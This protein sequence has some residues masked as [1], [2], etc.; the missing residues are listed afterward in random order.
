M[1]RRDALKNIGLAA[2]F[3]VITPNIFGMLQSCTSDSE[4]W[5]PSFLTSDEKSLV[6][7]IV[8]VFLPKTANTPSA[9]EV[10]VAQFIDTYI[11]DILGDKDQELTRG[12]FKKIIAI[13]TPDSSS[14]IEDVTTEEYK[15]LLDKYLL[16]EEIDQEALEMSNSEFLNQLKWMTIT[17]YKNSKFVGENILAYDPIPTEYYCG[18]LQELTA[19]KSWSL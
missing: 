7:N 10:N 1:K 3:A 6:T 2:G 11:H 17:A 8:D 16:S 9:S 14:T 18:D 5:T 15:N 4:S 12:G 13:L 19:G